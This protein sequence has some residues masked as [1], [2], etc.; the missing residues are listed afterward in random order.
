MNDMMKQIVVLVGAG[1]IGV[2]IARR[3]AAGKHLV[4]ADYSIGNAQA[5]ARTAG[6]RPSFE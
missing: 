4:L 6:R 2:A 3:V 5:A 1:S